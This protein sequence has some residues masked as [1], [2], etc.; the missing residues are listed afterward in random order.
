[1][2]VG[3]HLHAGRP[4]RPRDRDGIEHQSSADPSP[5]LLVLGTIMRYEGARAVG[6]EALQRPELVSPLALASFEE[7]RAIGSGEHRA[8][9][10]ARERLIEA[11]ARWVEPFDAVLTPPTTGEAPTP[12]TTGDPRFCLRW[13]L[14]GAPAITIP[15]GSGPAGLPL[16]L[17]LVARRGADRELLAIAAWA[18]AALGYVGGEKAAGL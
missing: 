8:A 5:H 9:L 2:S 18:E 4:L 16:G 13:T 14:L 1:M 3:G 15:S 10:A 11:F 7:G 17:Q 12:E 6:A